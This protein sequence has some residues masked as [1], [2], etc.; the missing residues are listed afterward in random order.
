MN[1]FIKVKFNNMNLIDASPDYKKLMEESNDDKIDLNLLREIYVH[2]KVE[3]YKL[4][5]ELVIRGCKFQC[6]KENSILSNIEFEK[7]SGILLKQSKDQR[8]KSINF[9]KYGLGDF[10]RKFNIENDQ[11]FNG[12]YIEGFE[13][14][15]ST[16]D[17]DKLKIEFELCGFNV[18]D[19]ETFKNSINEDSL[20]VDYESKIC[21]TEELSENLNEG[22]MLIE[23]VMYTGKYIVFRRFCRE[24]NIIYL[25]EIDDDIIEQFSL[26]K[27]VGLGKVNQVKEFL[28]LGNFTMKARIQECT[29][30]GIPDYCID[31]E[32]SFTQKI[33]IEDVFNDPK[34]NLFIEFCKNNDIDYLGDTDEYTM[35]KYSISKGVGAKR[36]SDAKEFLERYISYQKQKLDEVLDIRSEWYEEIKQYN[37]NEICEILNIKLENELDLNVEDIQGKTLNEL[38]LQHNKSIL[39]LI[40]SINEMYTPYEFINKLEIDSGLSDRDI[41][42]INKRYNEALT[43]EE[44]SDLEGMELTRERVRQL[45]KKGGNK[46]KEYA[47]E[48]KFIESLKILTKKRDYF[49]VKQLYTLLK[50]TYNDAYIKILSKEANCLH[51]VE[52]LDIIYFDI[53]SEI[54]TTIEKIIKDLP[55]V[56]KLE[57]ELEYIEK[58]LE[59][60]G[61]YNI[62]IG[63]IEKLL[64]YNNYKP[65]G[66]YYSNHKLKIRETLKL[67]VPN[68]IEYSFYY[69]E[70]AYENIKQLCKDYFNLHITS[71]FRTFENAL[72]D[73]GEVVLVDARTYLPK[74]KLDFKVG[75]EKYVKDILEKELESARVVNSLYIFNT[76]EDELKRY[77][78]TNKY[79]LY[80]LVSL[81]LTDNFS[82]GNGNSLDISK[83]AKGLSMTR[84]EV[85]INLLNENDNSIDRLK[86]GELLNWPMYKVDD[87]VGKSDK[88]LRIGDR[89]VNIESLTIPENVKVKLKDTVDRMIIKGYS[90]AHEVRKEMFMDTQ[91]YDLLDINK[92][93][94]LNSLSNFL[95]VLFN[96]L[97]IKG[98]FITHADSNY[99]CIED[100]ILDKFR[101][102]IFT[103]NDIKKFILNLGYA[104]VYYNVS[105]RKLLNNK[106]IIRVSDI[107]YVQSSKFN[108]DEDS[109][110]ILVNYIEENIG[111]QEYISL[112]KLNGYKRKLPR[113]EFRWNVHLMASILKENGYRQI[114]RIYGD[115]INDRIIIV[116]ENNPIKTFDDLVYKI[117]K[118]EYEG[119]MHEV[120]IYE[121]LSSIGIVKEHELLEDKTL[122]H[123]LKISDKFKV[124]DIGRV[125]II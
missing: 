3:F 32:S 125:E 61:I 83:S 123:E 84:E 103:R 20:K 114:E 105:F 67:L 106:K 40:D 119:N 55:S 73:S 35:Y 107:E 122:P 91:M 111:K 102:N 21:K 36:V 97:K 45:L 62:D 98:N 95:R 43:L 76:Y 109:I 15:N 112:N 53:D 10:V 50:H 118:E 79:F 66:E 89:I 38:N 22:R 30:D 124:D 104:D 23:D 85:I 13:F 8:Y 58:S 82:I 92:I 59:Y 34:Y 4:V 86:I 29:P 115:H 71:G 56:F 108:I 28:E 1:E 47:T 110:S 80:T 33:K 19:E 42:I 101:D 17:T 64:T 31:T 100:V 113:I 90:T 18:V 2:D 87:S 5:Q 96:N 12:I 6:E 78:I 39:Y 60:T 72:R 57:D 93:N 46:I 68:Y 75:A 16:I 63:N 48:K 26:F 65:Y 81:Y 121:F 54:E 41:L 77:G 9:E 52:A 27:G 70:H 74:N 44:I 99:E 11:F 49:T 51:K 88:L 24:N 7:N 37:I 117:I 69:D 94:D 116:R 25:D 14:L 120:K